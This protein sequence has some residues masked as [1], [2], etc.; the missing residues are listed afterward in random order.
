MKSAW[1]LDTE[2][3]IMDVCF[4]PAWSQSR[5]FLPGVRP[6]RTDKKLSNHVVKTLPFPFENPAQFERTIQAP[7]GAL[8]RLK[9]DG[10]GGRN[11]GPLVFQ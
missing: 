6:I 11:I 5:L 4:F 2:A 1:L 9:K 3:G 10:N 7:V 8:F